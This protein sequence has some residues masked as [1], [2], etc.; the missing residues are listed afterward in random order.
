M[1]QAMLTLQCKYL[2][3]TFPLL[4]VAI[5][6]ESLFVLQTAHRAVYEVSVREIFYDRP[7]HFHGTI[8]L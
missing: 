1:L 2:S 5:V 6:E 4:S 7:K 8:S 3:L